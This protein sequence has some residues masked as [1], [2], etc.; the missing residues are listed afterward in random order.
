MKENYTAKSDRCAL[1]IKTATLLSLITTRLHFYLKQGWFVKISCLVLCSMMFIAAMGQRAITGHV[2]DN[3]TRKPV[4]GASVMLKGTKVG[5]VTDENGAFFIHCKTGDFLKVSAI[6][7]SEKTILFNHQVKWT[8]LLQSAPKDLEDVKVVT[9]LGIVRDKR[10]LGYSTQIITSEQLTDAQSGNWTDALVGKVAGLDL[11]RSNSGPGGSN[12]IILRGENNLTGDNEALIVLDGVVLNTAKRSGTN[13]GEDVYGTGSDNMPADYG[14]NLGDLNPADFESVSILDG[15]SA[16]ALYGQRGANGAIIITTKS[17]KNKPVSINF[18]SN[19]NIQQINRWP[20]L[21]YEYGQGLDGA[22][23][24]SYGKMPDGRASTSST[25]SAYGPKFDGQYFY[26][27]SP[28]LQGRDSIATLWQPYT[29]QIRD[30]FQNGHTLTN[31]VSVS[32]GKGKTTSRFAYTNTRNNWIIP[33]TG[34]NLNTVSMAFN[35]D[36]N[37]KLQITTQVNY[38]NKTSDNLPGAGYGNQSLMYWFIFWQPNAD[39]NWLKNYWVNGQEGKAIKYP[40]SSYP[41][42]P[43]AIAYEYINRLQRNAVTGNVKALYKITPDISLQAR[44]SVDLAYEQRAQQRPWDAGTKMPKG[45][46]REQNIFSLEKSADITATYK[47]EI[48]KNF[49]FNLMLG[50]A[51]LRDNYTRDETRADSLKYPG[52]YSF[53]NS[54]GVLSARPYRSEFAINSLY[55]LLSGHY[56]DLVYLDITAR[57]DW[58]STLATPVRTTNAGFFYPSASMSFILS[59]AVKLPEFINYAK[60]RL[61]AASVGSGGTAPYLT[62]YNYTSAGTAYEGGLQNP[63]KLPN[64]E[65]KPLKTH[66]YETGFNVSMLRDRLTVDLTLYTGNTRNQILSRII[67]RASGYSTA[68]INAGQINNKGIEFTL[69]ATPVKSKSFKWS[70]TIIYSS[71]KNKIINLPD[72]NVVLYKGPQGGTEII[73][74]PGGSMGD[75]YGIGFQRSP[76]GQVVFDENTGFAKLTTDVIYLGNTTPKGRVSWGNKFNYKRFSLNFLFDAQYGA[77]AYSLTAYKLAEQGK[78]TNTLPGRY[79]G[80][81][82]NGVIQDADGSYRPNDVIATD[83]DEYYRSMYGANNGEGA[84]FSTDFIKFREA[85][86]SYSLNAKII[87]KLGLK[88]LSIGIY[89]RDLFIWSPWPDFDPEFGTLSGTDIIKGFEIG[90][91][92]SSRSFGANLN[93]GF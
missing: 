79:N 83:I 92:P 37:E 39:L 5:T 57:E 55:G 42:N 24:Y 41:E 16:A 62:A 10:E 4:A 40:Y 77:K 54:A 3:E 70:T 63:S 53:A 67:D 72:S 48:N 18:R 71:N 15:P 68:V 66:T 93:I 33:N 59:D 65:L 91:F 17:G 12:K 75:L 89:G 35:T 19:V 74:K 7:Y 45:S 38:N 44:T 14:S 23:Y 58:N 64:A 31:S 32:G 51:I 13:S 76:N 87:K 9:A 20:A 29:L 47:K 88:K 61:S 27:Y 46:Y 60:L 34:Y 80:I 30:F 28:V 49:G 73:A 84:T 50:G 86:I 1:T 6:G 21:Q 56:K 36:F 8:I 26:Q 25:S 78:T 43:Y 90:Q 22:D 11:V 2:L 69:N 81:I 52:L 85:T 82:G